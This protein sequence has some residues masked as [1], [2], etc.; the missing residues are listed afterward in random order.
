[1]TSRA[2]IILST[3]IALL[4]VIAGC[5]DDTAVAD[6]AVTTDDLG[7][8]AEAGT[9]SALPGDGPV[10]VTDGPV[11]TD[12]PVADSTPTTDAQA[13]LD[14]PGSTTLN[15]QGMV[16]SV[17]APVPASK[18]IVIW[19]VSYTSPDYA[20]KY[21]EAAVTSN[22]F[23]L[24]LATPPPTDALNAGALGVGLL[25]LVKDTTSLPDGKLTSFPQSEV[26]GSAPDMAL[27]YREKPLSG[28]PTWVNK[29]PMGYSCGKVSGKQGS[30]V[31]FTPTDCS[32]LQVT[33]SSNPKFPNWT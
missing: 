13:Q 7:V 16:L 30:F 5:S 8:G 17:G 31:T 15:A 10:T 23:A 11:A 2:L 27:I 24:S 4:V 14:G 32:K 3:S 29:F 33:V 28:A 20:Y 25:A 1:M 9:D 22:S 18:V 12:A 19:Q 26:I 6:S 21:G